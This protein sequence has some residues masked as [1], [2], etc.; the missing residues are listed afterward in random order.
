M[1]KC[2]YC[3]EEIQSEA[4]KCRYCGEWLEAKS[5]PAD[6]DKQLSDQEK[7]YWQNLEEKIHSQLECQQGEPGG[8]KPTPEAPPQQSETAPFDQTTAHDIEVK[9]QDPSQAHAAP[10]APQHAESHPP[11]PHRKA[12]AKEKRIDWFLEV[13]IN[14]YAVFTGRASRRE[15]WTFFLYNVIIGALFW[16]PACFTE[17]TAITKSLSVITLIWFLYWIAVLIPN[18]AVAARRL[19]DTNRSAWWLLIGYVPWVLL[20]VPMGKEN[21]WSILLTIIMMV[22]GV[23]LLVFTVQDSDAGDNQYG[24]NPKPLTANR[25]TSFSSL[26]IIVVCLFVVDVIVIYASKATQEKPVAQQQETPS[27]STTSY[28]PY[29]GQG[30]VPLTPNFANSG[31]QYPSYDTPLPDNWKKPGS[32][33][34]TGSSEESYRYSKGFISLYCPHCGKKLQGEGFRACPFCGVSLPKKF[35]RLGDA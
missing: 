35:W 8:G 25:P 13:M 18:L 27:Q 20:F 10:T 6:S 29:S 12:A 1:K 14:K 9:D 34:R 22:G 11:T 3:A 7:L 21:A 17:P 26:A 28:Q 31:Y 32:N 30:S 24:P 16:L 33:S 19:H 4:V 5:A 15:Y 2:P 23:I